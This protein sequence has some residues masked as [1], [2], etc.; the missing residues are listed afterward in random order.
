[1]RGHSQNGKSDTYSDDSN[2]FYAVIG[3]ELLQVVL[4]DRQNHTD[5]SRD[6]S[7]YEDNASDNFLVSA[8]K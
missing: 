2:V 3:E 4:H 1:M 6:N 5:Q 8:E 7:Y